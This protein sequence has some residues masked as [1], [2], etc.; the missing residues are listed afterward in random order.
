MYKYRTKGYS[1]DNITYLKET[2]VAKKLLKHNPLSF[3]IGSYCS[4]LLLIYM[5]INTYLETNSRTLNFPY[6]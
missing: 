5:I 6:L 4:V 3:S 1:F 2:L